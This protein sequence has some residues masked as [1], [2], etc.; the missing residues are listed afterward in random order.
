MERMGKKNHRLVRSEYLCD[1][2]INGKTLDE[3][4]GNAE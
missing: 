3:L 2:D 1:R 4:R